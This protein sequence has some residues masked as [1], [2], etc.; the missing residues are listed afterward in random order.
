MICTRARALH[1]RCLW[2]LSHMRLARNFTIAIDGPAASGKSSTARAVARELGF[3]YIDS[4]SI[5]RC[6]TLLALRRGIAP[7]DVG[8]HTDE[9]AE[10][11]SKASLQIK[12]QETTDRPT[13]TMIATGR[14]VV[15][16]VKVL[17]N[18][19]D[20]S[21]E[22]RTPDI[23]R[24][25][26]KIASANG[27]RE[28]ALRIQRSLAQDAESRSANLRQTGDES[29]AMPGGVVMDGRDI[30]TTVFPNAE[31]K[32]YLDASAMARAIRRWDEMNSQAKEDATAKR[33]DDSTELNRPEDAQEYH[34]SVED[35]AR[36]LE[37]RDYEDINR[38]NSPLRI[39][40]DAMV[41]DNTNLTFEQQVY[42]IADLARE[43]MGLE[44]KHDDL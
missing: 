15:P 28:A 9:I 34:P 36:E 21:R 23:N 26:S 25:V 31:L 10:L 27:V 30:G 16:T 43:R 1:S 17:L 7:S 29:K 20:V 6:A 32:I 33:L 3:G 41:I 8:Q 24:L 12:I 38:E 18:D 35:I 22:I 2:P 5:Y 19:E 37:Q 4:G 11:I 13:L 14:L 39:A 40:P 42:S 44:R